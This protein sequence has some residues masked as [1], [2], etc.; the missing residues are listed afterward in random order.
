MEKV[1]FVNFNKKFEKRS[2]KFPPTEKCLWRFQKYSGQSINRIL[3]FKTQKQNMEKI[4]N[5]SR[6]IGNFVYSCIHKHGNLE[7]IQ[8]SE[9]L[10]L[11]TFPVRDAES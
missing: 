6:K 2:S 4:W 3:Y 5:I 10:Q 7:K 9:N 8:L 1:W 11:C